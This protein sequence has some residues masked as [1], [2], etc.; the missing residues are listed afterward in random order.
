MKKLSAGIIITDGNQILLGHSTGNH[1]WDIPKGMVE[2]GE[3]RQDCAVRETQEEFGLDFSN[4]P[5]IDLGEFEYSKSKDLHLFLAKLILMPDVK[6]C[7]C[8]SYFDIGYGKKPEID[9]FKLFYLD[10]CAIQFCSSMMVSYK[11]WGK[12]IT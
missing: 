5:L 12:Y 10:S 3:N 9:N 8:T 6:Q 2:D 11:Q 7:K 1:Y 4:H